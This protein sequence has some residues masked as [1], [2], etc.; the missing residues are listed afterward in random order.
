MGGAEWVRGW[1]ID[2][3]IA[4]INALGF[5]VKISSPVIGLGA[6]TEILGNS[7][8][9]ASFSGTR[10]NSISILELVE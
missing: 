8:V 5:G 10:K 9:E 2:E 1:D 7:R 6:S 4:A 3:N